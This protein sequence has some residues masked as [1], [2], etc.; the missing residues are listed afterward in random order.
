MTGEVLNQTQFM[1][2][3]MENYFRFIIENPKPNNVDFNP[4]PK[5]D[6]NIKNQEDASWKIDYLSYLL[7]L[8][9]P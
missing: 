5:N 3:V 9:Y 2:F 6:I 8:Q 1:N 7:W 4:H